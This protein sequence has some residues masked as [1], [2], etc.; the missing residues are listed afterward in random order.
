[1]RR[2]LS[3]SGPM[4]GQER[5]QQRMIRNRESASNSRRKKKEY[6]NTLEETIRFVEFLQQFN[7]Y[8]E[9]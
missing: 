5:K 4:T 8:Y 3:S 7:L 2:Q 6:L 9:C 1:M